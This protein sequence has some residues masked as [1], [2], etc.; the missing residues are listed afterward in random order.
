MAPCFYS[1]QGAIFFISF[2]F[3]GKTLHFIETKGQLKC[4]NEFFD[5]FRRSTYYK[6]IIIGLRAVILI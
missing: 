4:F 6:G 1:K 5:P 3:A 2:Y